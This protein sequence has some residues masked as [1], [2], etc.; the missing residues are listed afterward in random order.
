MNKVLIIDDDIGMVDTLTDILHE[1]GFN[2]FS[3]KTGKQGLGKVKNEN[4]QSVLLD[5]KLPDGNGI[6]V[7]K[8]IIDSKSETKVIVMTGFATME[9]AIE[10]LNHGASSYITKPFNLDEL[11]A[12]LKQAV[13]Q[14]E[15]TS[16]KIAA[17]TEVKRLKEFNENILESL[18]DAIVIFD[19]NQR[20]E[21][22]NP[23]VLSEFSLEEKKVLGKDLF[24]VVPFPSPQKAERL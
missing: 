11:K 3:A 1:E 5:L 10:A 24:E 20:V 8:E 22:A 18:P 17:E 6:D 23:V 21:Y 13:L 9:N 12:L 7:L 16:Q 19:Q 14:S 2:I 15:L 4:F